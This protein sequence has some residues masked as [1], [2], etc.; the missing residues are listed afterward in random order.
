MA[1]KKE[2]KEQTRQRIL[3]SAADLFMLKG[4]EHVGINEI[5]TNA[6]LT[7]GAFYAHFSSKAELY[8]ESIVTSALA[9]KDFLNPLHPSAPP[10][11]SLISHYLSSSH[12]NGTSMRCPLAFLVSDITQ[13]D[14]QVKA[15]YTKVFKG[16][17]LYLKQRLEKQDDVEG[18]NAHSQSLLYAATMIGSLSL[19]RALDDEAL[20]LDLLNACQHALES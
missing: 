14:A 1:W 12:M 16:F 18:G 20:A 7:R 3:E 19:A 17:T 10:F 8:A 6:K 15:A 2:Q 5:M 4:F 9:M 11:N 13:Q